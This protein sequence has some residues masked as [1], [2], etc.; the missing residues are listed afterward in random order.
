LAIPLDPPLNNNE[1]FTGYLSDISDDKE[2]GE[3]VGG[4]GSKGEG[5]DET[6]MSGHNS[7]TMLT[8]LG[9]DLF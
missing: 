3:E 6:Q 5:A 7:L 2:D 8:T 4:E 1:V 9:T